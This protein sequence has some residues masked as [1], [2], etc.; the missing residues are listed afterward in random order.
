MFTHSIDISTHRRKSMRH[1]EHTIQELIL[2][3]IPEF[4]FIVSDNYTF[5]FANRTFETIFGSVNS[6][7]PCYSMLRGTTEPCKIC[8]AKD[9]ISKEEGQVWVW[10]DNHRGKIY[11]MHGYPFQSRKEPLAALGIGIDITKKREQSKIDKTADQPEITR[12]CCYCKGIHNTEQRQ[13]QTVEEYFS[14]K[15]NLQFSHGICPDCM[16]VNFPEIK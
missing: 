14:A 1:A 12:I 10:E 4:V 6:S 7:I 16:A 11:E 2:D 9:V 5:H 13:W 8:P 3:Q 15:D